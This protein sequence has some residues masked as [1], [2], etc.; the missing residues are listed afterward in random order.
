MRIDL[1]IDSK[2]LILRLENGQRRLAYAVVNAIN[3]TAKRVQAAEH[4]HVRSKFEIRQEKFFFGSPERPGGV[5]ARISPFANVRRAIPYA[6]VAIQAPAGRGA[7][8]KR[9]FLSIFETG[10]LRP[11]SR[12]AKRIAVP[13]TGGPARPTF[14]STIPPEW[15][16]GGMHFVAYRGGKKVVR[17]GKRKSRLDQTAFDEAG[18]VHV[19]TDRTPTQWKGRNRTFIAVGAVSQEAQDAGESGTGGVYQRTGPGKHDVRLVYL[20]QKPMQLKPRLHWMQ[21]AQQVANTWFGEEMER[22]AANAVARSRG[23]GL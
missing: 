22:E 6:E 8:G 15:T 18:Q 21:T 10:G 9:T 4:E 12:Q 19:P 16:W 11:K 5:A 2:E 17:K 20:F 3:N 23:R 1:D 14:A 13:I 7:W